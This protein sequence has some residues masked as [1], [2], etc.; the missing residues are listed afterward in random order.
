MREILKEE[1][2]DETGRREAT[3]YS[4]RIGGVEEFEISNSVGKAGLRAI[5]AVCQTNYYLSIKSKDQ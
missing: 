2:G 3:G 1:R 4:K 5:Q